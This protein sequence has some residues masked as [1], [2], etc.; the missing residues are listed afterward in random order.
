MLYYRRKILLALIEALG[1]LL[2]AKQLQKYLF[3]FT[4]KQ[5]EK[6]YDF[7]PYFYGCY[8]FQAD[9]DIT[10]LSNYGYI[11]V[12]ETPN[13]RKIES[14]KKTNCM[15]EL[16]VFDQAYLRDIV[17]TFG[18]LPQDDLIKYTYDNY[19][20][21]AINSKIAEKLLST[22][23]L[24]KVKKQ[25]KVINTPQL[26]SIGY[27]GISLEKYINLLII[28]DVRVLC[29][30][31][32]NAYSQKYGFSKTQLKTACAGVGI[33]YIH[34]PDLGIN[35]D[36]RKYLY[37]QDD[38]DKLFEEYEN[39]TLKA[40]ENALLY[41][42]QLITQKKRVALTCFE[43]DPKQCHRTRVANEVLKRVKDLSFSLLNR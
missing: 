27:E 42:V 40:N 26:F 17:S 20:Y 21:Y 23:S 11:K 15:A 10:T 33:E 41:V 12:Y 9:Q 18:H 35:S 37:T 38:Y 5:S 14:V 13:G 3:L 36:N 43:K 25:K 24:Q 6:S 34:I 19:P 4:R 32:K 2:T 7:I 16:G 28:N 31:R 1:G 22:E 29:D 30:V 39:T 8:S